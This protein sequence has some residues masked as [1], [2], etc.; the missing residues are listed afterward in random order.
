MKSVKIEVA[1]SIILAISFLLLS[2]AVAG[3]RISSVDCGTTS[4]ASS[5][6]TAVNAASDGDT[7][8][9][10]A[11]TCN[12]GA[13]YVTWTNKNI[14]VIGAGI[15]QTIIT[16]TGRAFLVYIPVKSS[17]RISGMTISGSSS[18]PVIAV[19]SF[20]HVAPFAAM[21]GWR[22]DHIKFDFGSL[23][24]MGVYVVGPNW[25]LIDHCTFLATRSDSA[26]FMFIS[27]YSYLYY[28]LTYAGEYSWSLPI[29]WGTEKALY[30]ED[31]TFYSPN[32]TGG[33]HP[34]D[35]GGG[36]RLVFRYNT[37]TGGGPIFHPNKSYEL[38]PAKYEVYNNKF[39]AG[40]YKGYY[41]FTV[42][43]GGSGVVFK[44]QWTGFDVAGLNLQERRISTDQSLSPLGKCSTDNALDGYVG[45]TRTNP[46][47][48]GW[49]C[50]AQVGRGPGQVS[51]PVYSWYNGTQA[52]CATT[53]TTCTDTFLLVSTG[54]G[55]TDY[56]KSTP[57]SNGEVDFVNNGTTPKPGYTP[58][59][60]P[61]PLAKPKP[62][63]NLRISN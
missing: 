41:P 29:D 6:Q 56:I 53:Q 61:H 18:T 34:F 59:I 10:P 47:S 37:V 2:N 8:L 21:S 63:V 20:Y 58:Y 48:N 17:F 52:D 62:P 11:G 23:S 35:V 14:N 13:S 46:D 9:I 25:G 36:A 33:A 12:W 16:V 5:V 27:F 43:G 45:A 49:P 3:T 54:T 31:C 7:I 30:I 51:M 55:I 57:H 40:S 39:F 44:N 28:E 24:G 22:V 32:N 50:Y 4:S 42:Q 19:N 1:L 26:E 60:Y 38:G 15:D